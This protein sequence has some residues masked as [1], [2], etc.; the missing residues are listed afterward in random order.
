MLSNPEGKMS[1]ITRFRCAA[2][3]CIQC[4]CLHSIK[5]FVV[6]LDA[7]VPWDYCTSPWGE[8]EKSPQGSL[9]N[10]DGATGPRASGWS[11]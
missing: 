2:D 9:F 11:R 8:S 1:P 10:A 3:S 4:S 7:H 5:E 6:L